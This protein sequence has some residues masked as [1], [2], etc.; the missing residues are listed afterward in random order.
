MTRF[1]G[2]YGLVGLIIVAALSVAGIIVLAAL[3][4]SVPTTLNDLAVVSVG[5]IAGVTRLVDVP[6]SASTVTRTTGT[7]AAGG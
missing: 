5:A 1:A 4:I 3:H 2:V 7:L 6:A